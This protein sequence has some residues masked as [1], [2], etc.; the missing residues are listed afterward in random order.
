MPTQVF[1]SVMPASSE[2][3]FAWHARQGAFARLCPPWQSI[4]IVEPAPLENGSR[5]RLRMKKGPLWLR[6]VAEHRD[7]APGRGF[8]D[9]QAAGPFS[10]WVHHHEFE[11]RDGA[12]T[13]RDRI[14]YKLPGGALGRAFGGPQVRRDLATTFAFRHETTARDLRRHATFAG[15][16]RLRVAIS[17]AGGLVGG[18]LDP[19]LTTGGH[20]TLRLVRSEKG[21]GESTL[22]RPDA[23]LLDPRALD[24]VDAVV[25]LA[26]ESIAAGRWTE[27]RKSRIRS[28][29]VE[30]TRKLIRSLAGLE[31]PPKTFVCASAIGYYGSR[32]DQ[33]VDELSAPG[34]GFL[35]EVCRDWELA[36]REASEIG[37]RVVSLR[38]GVILT[39]AG[40]A[41]A[42]MLP[43][44]QLGAGGRLG[45][46]RQFMSWIS[47]DD[48]VG[49]IHQALLDERLSGPVNVVAP[50]PVTNAELTRALGRV[51]GRPTLFPVPALGA[52]LAFGQ[53]ADEMLL[54]S[55]RVRP[56]KLE[57]T[58]FE[59][60]DMEL[61]STL[62]RLLG[63]LELS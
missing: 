30:G 31:R 47:I 32:G 59:F 7:V 36:A 62:S 6:W 25:H 5:V 54:T 29:R 57:E 46:G 34:E 24:G 16:P 38:F 20:R 17:G 10:R 45:S 43:P 41:L 4:E 61:E 14:D 9:F 40:G 63:K 23:G 1:E 28:S 44:F 60:H 22:W 50:R 8:V 21:Q 49:A 35:A 2:E 52:R 3:L 51:L 37:M 19:F 42:K 56:R 18:T 13:L 11:E 15:R 12:S 48:A 53:M 39:P 26:G 58:G 55:T 27:K 33:V